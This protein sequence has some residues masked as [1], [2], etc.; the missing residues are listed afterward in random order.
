MGNTLSRLS[1]AKLQSLLQSAIGHHR[2]ERLAQAEMIYRQVRAMAPRNFDA[3]HLS[4]LV[5]YQQERVADAID[6]L[7]RAHRL[8]PRHSTCE[9]RLAAALIAGQRLAEADKHLRHALQLKPDLV[10]GWDTLATCLKAQDKLLEAAACHEKAVAVKPDF[11]LGWVNYGFT[12]RLLGRHEEALT[13]HQ[14]ALD[15]DPKFAPAR[16]GRAQSLQQL[17]RLRESVA[18]YEAF[19][20]L[21][22]QSLEA[23]SNRLFAL[24]NLEEIS[25]E[26]LFA[27]HVAYG[28]ALKPAPTPNFACAPDPERK[29][30]VAFL[31]PDLREH[32]C[33]YFLEPMLRQLDREAFEI[34]LYHDHFREDAVSVR[35][36]SLGAVWRNVSGQSATQL[37]ATIRADA[38]DVLVDIAGHTGIINRLPVLH[39]KVAPVQVTYLGYPDTTGVPAIDYRFT[40]ALAD[41]I[42]EADAFATEMLVR[43]AP[44]AWSYS[45]PGDAPDVAPLPALNSGVVTFGCFNDLA[46]ITDSALMA[47]GR[48]LAAVPGARL[49]L[50]GAGLGE[51]ATRARMERRMADAGIALERV[52][53]LE[54]T[55]DVRSHL[56]LYHGIDIALD[57]FPY[58][59]TTTTCEA[60][61]MGVPV[62]TLRGDRHVARVGASLTTAIGRSDWIAEDVDGYVQLAAA[63]ARRLPELAA[64]RAGLRDNMVRSSLLD[65]A[66][67]AERLG[68]ALRGC[69]TKWCA[70]VPAEALE[71]TA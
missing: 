23:R 51:T 41:P 48:V 25:R 53:L 57:A 63:W 10:E 6:L 44:T 49:R 8:D 13:C 33:A 68:A 36:R 69:W 40:D 37:E 31:S 12:L 55:P 16:F 67:Q 66:G 54:R 17:H 56:A 71:Q 58:N 32:A 29:L 22:P 60:L 39:R 19:L 14:R 5:A 65:H 62:V 26:Q 3:L 21:Q 7:G 2:A 35:L 45:P 1:P 42:G 70:R 24:H 34:Y 46:K 27:E 47:W 28:Q 30:R 9:L 61:W 11:A 15:L 50:K 20:T 64:L 43:F 59:G 52:E 38:P 4:G 18:E